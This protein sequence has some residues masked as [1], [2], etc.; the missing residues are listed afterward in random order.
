MRTA[1]AL[2]TVCLLAGRARGDARVEQLIKGYEREQTSCRV[3]EGGVANMLDGA[4]ML[5]ER[6]HDDGLATDVKRLHDAHEVVASYC[7][8][9]A[10]TLELLRADPSATYKSLEKQ[11]DD[12]DNHIR[13]LRAASKKALDETQPLVQRWIARINAA[14]I[15]IDKSTAPSAPARPAA[16]AE[17]KRDPKLEPRPDVKVQPRAEPKPEPRP[18]PKPEAK[19]EPR[20][21]PKA[22]AAPVSGRFP[23]GRAVKLPQLAGRWEVSGDATTDVADYV[24]GGSHTSVVAETFTNVSCATQLARLEAKAYGRHAV[25]EQAR[26]GQ[27][28]RVR[29]PSSETPTIVACASTRSGSALVTLDAPDAT[30]ADLSELAWMMLATLPK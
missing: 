22:N 21:T 5:L 17:S 4:T 29:L 19:P 10:A 26:P 20:A 1:I 8:A 27:V 23:S 24:E 16:N 6:E 2:I 7:T 15:E 28:W 18:E 14:R 25:K 12:R 13:A 11:I 3:H 9:L 30:H